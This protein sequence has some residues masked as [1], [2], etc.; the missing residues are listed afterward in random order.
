MSTIRVTHKYQ[1]AELE[2]PE[3]KNHLE[4]FT[5][6]YPKWVAAVDKLIVA[7]EK[8]QQVNE[9]VKK[10]FNDYQPPVRQQDDGDTCTVCGSKKSRSKKT[11][12]MFCYKCYMV[13]LGKA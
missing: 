8:I 3:G 10:V 13:K 2:I 7:Q 1:G 6:E 9:T 11:G 12:N 4:F 5:E